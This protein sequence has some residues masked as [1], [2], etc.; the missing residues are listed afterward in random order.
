MAKTYTEK[1]K[2]PRWQR[3]R[4]EIMERDDFRCCE[5]GDKDSTLNVHH[6]YYEKGNDPWDYANCFLKC[7]CASCH[8][9]WHKSRSTLLKNIALIESES[10]GIE[11][12]EW[13]A[14]YMA[15]DGDEGL[16]ACLEC[17]LFDLVRIKD[18]DPDF[19]TRVINTL[20]YVVEGLRAKK[21]EKPTA[22][23]NA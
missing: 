14:M 15:G 12:I 13:L 18:A 3:K 19:T 1:L 7:L 22:K 9:S 2:D 11:P 21:T 6:L 4:L 17:L 16:M 23:I 20:E 8:E 10:L 5:C